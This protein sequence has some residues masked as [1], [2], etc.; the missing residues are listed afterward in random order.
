MATRCVVSGLGFRGGV[1]PGTPDLD[2][3]DLLACGGPRLKWP[4]SAAVWHEWP[5]L[6]QIIQNPKTL[7]LVML[8]NICLTVNSTYT[9]PRA[10]PFFCGLSCA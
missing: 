9:G 8:K 7:P 10:P 2:P 1:V 5:I 3:D 6:P 4:R